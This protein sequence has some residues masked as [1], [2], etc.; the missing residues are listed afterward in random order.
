M[1]GNTNRC[2]D[3]V[4]AAAIA[5]GGNGGGRPDFAQAGGRDVSKVEEA[6]PEIVEES[7]PVEE[8]KVE[9]TTEAPKTKTEELNAN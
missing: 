9:E 7:T 6:T 4:K 5:T 3:L 1:Q 8:V 2:G